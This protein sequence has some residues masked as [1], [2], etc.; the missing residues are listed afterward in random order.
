MLCELFVDLHECLCYVEYRVR[1]Q[2]YSYCFYRFVFF[3]CRS[4]WSFAGSRIALNF[5]LN[6]PN[7]TI[8]WMLPKSKGDT[9]PSMVIHRLWSLRVLFCGEVK[10]TR[11]PWFTTSQ[12]S[13]LNEELRS[14]D[15]L[16]LNICW[17]LFLDCLWWP[18]LTHWKIYDTK[19]DRGRLMIGTWLILVVT[20]SKQMWKFIILIFIELYVW[21]KTF[22]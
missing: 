9:K 7:S 1:T 4:Q 16:R 20:T 8:I 2:F 13:D 19:T 10:M 21:N 14:Y 15:Q 18:F 12:Y 22:S 6:Y 11:K 5:S 17:P 3:S